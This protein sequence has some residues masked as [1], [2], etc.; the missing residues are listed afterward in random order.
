MM[1]ARR[2]FPL[3]VYPSKRFGFRL[4]RAC[5][6]ARR[7][8]FVMSLR[9]LFS[10]RRKAEAIPEDIGRELET[11]GQWSPPAA[12]SSSPV[13]VH[14]VT[15]EREWPA[16]AWA[17]ASWCCFTE[18]EWPILIHDDGTLT[19]RAAT[20]LRASFPAARLIPRIEADAALQPLLMAFPFCESF[21]A[22]HASALRVLDLPHFAAGERFIALAPDVLFFRHPREIMDWVQTGELSSWLLA[23][24]EAAS[25]VSTADARD[26][27]GIDPWPHASDAIALLQRTSLD[28]DFLDTVL[29]RTS[30]LSR[31]AAL[32]AT[33]LNV[34]GA[35]RGR[36]GRLPATYE[37]AHQ[38]P[39]AADIVARHYQPAG[40]RRYH[41]DARTLVRPHLFATL[42]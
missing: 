31:D 35:S 5:L 39:P 10:R 13:S 28:L 42:D 18:C 30:L 16:A 37:V 1:V 26:E 29:A 6:R 17:L 19:E 38:S 23:D 14:V 24:H 20:Q 34:L 15:G 8:P 32:V 41:E 7:R 12:D 3:R 36:G 40:W 27:L 25:G 2:K 4:R 21:R 22:Q 11:I 9:S 33:T